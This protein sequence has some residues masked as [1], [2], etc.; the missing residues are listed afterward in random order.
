MTGIEDL[1]GGLASTVAT[2]AGQ[3]SQRLEM[4]RTLTRNF[5]EADDVFDE[6]SDAL[7]PDAR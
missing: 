6:C 3:G 5:P 7:G 4:G 1:W 2:F